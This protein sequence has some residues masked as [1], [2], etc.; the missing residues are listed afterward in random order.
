LGTEFVGPSDAFFADSGN[1][2]IS[3]RAIMSLQA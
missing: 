3:Q 1:I 2:S